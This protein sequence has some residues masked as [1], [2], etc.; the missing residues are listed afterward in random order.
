MGRF[1]PVP[2]YR[3]HTYCY[4]Y[5]LKKWEICTCSP[6]S[7]TY[8]LLSIFSVEMGKFV[9]PPPPPKKNNLIHTVSVLYLRVVFCLNFCRNIGSI[10]P[11]P[12]L[13]PTKKTSFILIVFSCRCSLW[14]KTT[15]T[16][17]LK[18]GVK[19][20]QPPARRLAQCFPLQ[21]ENKKFRL[22]NKKVQHTKLQSWARDK[23]A[24]STWPCFQATQLF[25][26]A[27]LLYLSW[28][29]RLYYFSHFF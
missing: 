11:C 10:V 18:P 27:T 15:K 20:T 8:L 4:L 28:T 13:P 21:H 14:I 26:I 5:S 22:A 1:V 12:P 29:P 2:Q 16:T 6:I 24:A 17:P 19:G 3:I 25:V 7:Y 9:P 23:A